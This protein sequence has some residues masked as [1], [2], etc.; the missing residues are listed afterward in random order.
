MSVWPVLGPVSG[1]WIAR[2]RASGVFEKALE[3]HSR[4]VSIWA[5]VRRE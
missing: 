1:D 4:M 2:A 5:W 3:D